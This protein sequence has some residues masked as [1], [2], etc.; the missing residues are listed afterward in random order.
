MSL[1]LKDAGGTVGGAGSIA[2]ASRQCYVTP[3]RSRYIFFAVGALFLL[4]AVVEFVRTDNYTA[5]IVNAIAA[6]I[7]FFLGVAPARRPK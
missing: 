2:V 5:I 1:L 7:F 4:F 6:V 3:M